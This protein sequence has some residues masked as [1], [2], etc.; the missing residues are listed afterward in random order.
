[1]SKACCT[2]AIQS[3]C[4]TE[5]LRRSMQRGPAACVASS[6]K[7]ATELDEE[8]FAFNYDVCV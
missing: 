7:I 5:V 2:K 6:P 1:L 8:M 4:W 3:N